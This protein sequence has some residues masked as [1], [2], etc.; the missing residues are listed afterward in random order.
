[1]FFTGMIISGLQIYNADQ[2]EH[3]EP[4][5]TLSGY[6]TSGDF[7]EATFENWES[8]FLAIAVMVGASV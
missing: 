7:V 1:V 8:D 5:V 2:T 4:A 3:N 6:L